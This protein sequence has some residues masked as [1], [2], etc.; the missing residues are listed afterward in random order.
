MHFWFVARFSFGSIIG[1]QDKNEA[2]PAASSGVSGRLLY[3]KLPLRGSLH[4]PALS[5]RQAMGYPP[6]HNKNKN[7][8]ELIAAEK[9]MIF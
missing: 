3:E 1:L 8:L 9:E 7:H 6:E 2:D 5:P 4:L